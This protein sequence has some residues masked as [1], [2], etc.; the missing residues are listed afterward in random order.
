MNL[1]KAGD[2]RMKMVWSLVWEQDICQVTFLMPIFL[3]KESGG[4]R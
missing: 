4:D 2:T 1:I 3:S